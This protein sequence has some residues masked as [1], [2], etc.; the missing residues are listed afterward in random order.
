VDL[1]PLE[2]TFD[3]GAR[4]VHG[5]RV[6]GA[7]AIL[8]GEP[9]QAGL[10]TV[11]ARALV[12]LPGEE[13]AQVAEA[14]GCRLG[15]DLLRQWAPNDRRARVIGDNLAVI[16]YG[17]NVG[18]LRRPAMAS[19]LSAGLAELAQRCWALTWRAVRRRLNGAADAVATEAVMWASR[20]AATGATAPAITVEWFSTR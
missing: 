17:A 1:A 15:L 12:A 14:W 8:W 3:G 6:A 13:H 10:R 7:G 16:R 11:L 5:R 9:D 2:V 20:L 18:R 4:L 19:L